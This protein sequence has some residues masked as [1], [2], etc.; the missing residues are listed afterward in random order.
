MWNPLFFF[1]GSRDFK[2][3]GTCSDKIWTQKKHADGR[4]GGV[5]GGTVLNQDS[6]GSVFSDSKSEGPWA[7]CR[8]C[9]R[10]MIMQQIV[11]FDTL[12]SLSRNAFPNMWTKCF[13][14]CTK[15]IHLLSVHTAYYYSIITTK[16]LLKHTYQQHW[17]YCL[18]L[19]TPLHLLT[20][21]YAKQSVQWS[22]V[23]CIVG[24]VF[25]F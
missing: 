21:F 20:S 13:C 10:S 9:S 12:H 6:L 7:R 15:I 3:E 14:F 22:I 24:I 17:A 8:M 5:K 23:S 16:W 4:P 11:G 2:L 1:D 25:L 19:T 18:V